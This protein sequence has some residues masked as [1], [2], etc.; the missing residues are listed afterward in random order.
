MKSKSFEIISRNI[1]I[2]FF[3]IGKSF[4]VYNG[5]VFHSVFVSESI[6][7]FRFGEFSFTRVS[8]KKK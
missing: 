8:S 7:G 1:K 3:I 2:D 6:V 5:R 4:K